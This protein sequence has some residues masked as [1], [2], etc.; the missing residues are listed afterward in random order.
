MIL[1]SEIKT[2]VVELNLPEDVVDSSERATVSV[3]GTF[4]CY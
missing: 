4:D 1:E 2:E 3:V